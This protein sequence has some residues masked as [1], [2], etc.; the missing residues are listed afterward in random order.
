M[1]PG[2]SFCDYTV[3]TSATTAQGKEEFLVL[4]PV[5]SHVGSV[6]QDDLHLDSVVDT[7]TEGRREDAVASTS[8]PATGNADCGARTTKSL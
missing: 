8:D 3:G 7:K 4:A 6:G 5:G 1:E 2:G